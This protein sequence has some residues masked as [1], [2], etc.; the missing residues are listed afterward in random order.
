LVEVLEA[1]GRPS[2]LLYVADHGE[3]L[4]DDSRNLFGH[5]LCN[6]KDIP[7]PMLLWFSKALASAEHERVAAAR[8]HLS[9][10]VS[11][12]AIFDTLLDLGRVKLGR[13]GASTN[14]LL[15][16]TIRESRR[17]MVTNDDRVVDF[18]AMYRSRPATP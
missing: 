1:D 4:R 8:S 14:S 3:N 11:T 12:S 16:S 17:L 15:R 7:I 13:A 2:A 10:R 9:R 18:D 6:D 5:F